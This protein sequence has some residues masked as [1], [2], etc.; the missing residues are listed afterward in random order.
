MAKIK[1]HELAKELEIKSK[2]VITFLQEK[3]VDVKAAQS[4]IEGDAVEWVKKKFAAANKEPS[5]QKDSSRIGQ[6]A[7]TERKAQVE[8]AETAEKTTQTAAVQAEGR[9][10]QTTDKQDMNKEVAG[11][12]SQAKAHKKAKTIIVVNNPQNSRMKNGNSGNNDRRNNNGNGAKNDGRRNDGNR[13]S[14]NRQGNRNNNGMRMESR[15]L[16]KPLTKPSQPVMPDEKLLS[17]ERAAKE[18]AAKAAAEAERAAKAAEIEA[19]KK[20]EET[21]PVTTVITE[22]ETDLATTATTEMETDPATT[23]TTE[24][25]TDPVTTV[26][27]ETVTETSPAAEMVR[28]RKGHPVMEQEETRT[29]R[30]I[31]AV[32]EII[33]AIIALQAVAALVRAITVLVQMADALR[34]AMDGRTIDSASRQQAKVL[35]QKLRQRIR[36]SAET[37]AVLTS[38][39]ATRNRE[40]TRFTKKTA[41]Q[42]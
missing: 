4:S 13:G 19:Q 22:T 36:K 18:A 28:V 40:E 38:R 26:I 31:T 24:T 16:I 30:V 7:Q 27:T 25:E 2:D 39:S 41:Q 5:D 35:Q 20:E 32:Q 3:G 17:R 15:P 10:E 12:D 1:V 33:R 37:I 8:K 34:T 29:V 14:Q 42:H 23:V 6:A 9:E 11:Q 21:D